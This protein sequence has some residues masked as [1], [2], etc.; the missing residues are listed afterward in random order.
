MGQDIPKQ[1]INVYDK[2]VLIYTLESFQKHPLINASVDVLAFG[3]VIYALPRFLAAVF[4]SVE[5]ANYA[6]NFADWAHFAN[7]NVYLLIL[8]STLAVSIS[9]LAAGIAKMRRT[10]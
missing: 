8:I 9:L 1:F 7:G 5:G 3:S 4:G 2:P 6:V 10:R